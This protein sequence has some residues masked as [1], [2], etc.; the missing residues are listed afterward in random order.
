MQIFFAT[1]RTDQHG[2][3]YYFSFLCLCGK[4]PGSA[5]GSITSIRVNPWP[6]LLPKAKIIVQL[7]GKLYLTY[8]MPPVVFL[9]VY[10]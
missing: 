2:F 7:P 8:Q 1:D 5:A 6:G 4:P 9:C 10:P 3:F